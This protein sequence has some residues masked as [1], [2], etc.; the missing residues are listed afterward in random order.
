MNNIKIEADNLGKKAE[1]EE[2][3]AKLNGGLK[4]NPE[5]GKKISNY[6]IGSIEAKLT[7]LNK[8]NQK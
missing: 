1:M 5:A 4:N 3:I 8:M 7:I 2:Q 6:L